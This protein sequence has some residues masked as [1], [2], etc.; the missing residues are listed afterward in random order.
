MGM[1]LVL[2][3]AV[4]SVMQLIAYL[5]EAGTHAGTRLTVMAGWVADADRWDT[6]EAR[7]TALLRRNGISHVH[8]TDLHSG[9]APFKGWPRE[10]RAA[11]AAEIAELC[12][13]ATL[14]GLV[15]ILDN[16]QYDRVY[17]GDD[18]EMR[19]KRSAL[20]SKYGV[21][22]RVAISLIPRLIERADL[23][24]GSALAVVIE[25]GH[26]NV[27][28]APEI[29]RAFNEL[30]D[31]P[32]RSLLKS[33][34][35]AEKRNSAGLQAADMLAYPAWRGETDNTLIH[36]DVDLL[37][38]DSPLRLPIDAPF[39]VP[40]KPETLTDLREGTLALPR[41]RRQLRRRQDQSNDRG[42]G[43]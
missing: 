6:F 8:G 4:S 38:D 41:Y 33:V 27:G 7:W 24:N 30:A 13:R 18:A 14:F 39:R 21:C 34:T 43:G 16:A 15:A 19:K 11:L 40:I 1:G 23:A 22:F 3:G 29:F 26:Q 5:D 17:I 9:K 25:S 35:V 36:Q 20:D 12:T 10:R 37:V 28:A 31:E 42:R 2:W 32:I